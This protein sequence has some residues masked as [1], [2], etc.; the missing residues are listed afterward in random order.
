MLCSLGHRLPFAQRGVLVLSAWMALAMSAGA[1]VIVY[2][3]KF[4]NVS[5]FNL[6]GNGHESGYLVAPVLGGDGVMLFTN[7]RD[8]TYTETTPAAKLM[9]GI[10]EHR[11]YKTVASAAV[12]SETSGDSTFVAVGDVKTWHSFNTPTLD[13]HARIAKELKGRA[14]GASPTENATHPERIGFAY[15][16]DWK[17][18]WDEGQTR[19][20]N[21]AGLT[22]DETVAGLKEFLT[23]RGF[24]VTGIE[25]LA[26]VSTSPLPA[27]TAGTAY[28]R[29]LQASGGTGSITWGDSGTLPDGLTL[30][31]SGTISGTPTTPGT[32]SF[33][34]TATDSGSPAQSVSKV[35]SITINPGALTITTTSPLTSGTVGS[36][37]SLSFASSGGSGGL[38]WSLASGSNPLP[39]GLS[40]TTT[41]IL[42]GTPTTDGTTTFTVQVQDTSSPVQ[43][44]T[45]EFSLTI[46]P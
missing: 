11:E 7:N 8:K 6:A 39:D 20:A 17:L 21:R 45:K 30:S 31:S 4:K 24:L 3:M 37:Y 41:G 33:T 15:I 22:V 32:S 40:L 12:T 28:S 35:F 5:G 29:T 1:Q 44:F 36:A 18:T 26:I 38:T 25:P 13:L 19:R 23:A 16:E 42:S 14:Q 43:T 46:N 9:A 27:G 2:Q 34:V 10:T